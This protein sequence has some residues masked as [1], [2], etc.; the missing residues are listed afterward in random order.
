MQFGNFFVGVYNHCFST[1]NVD[2]GIE[3]IVWY[4]DGEWDIPLRLCWLEV[5]RYLGF[6][7]GMLDRCQQDS[8][9]HD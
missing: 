4:I 9:I 8:N 1:I 2:A 7:F 3:S 5:M 6:N